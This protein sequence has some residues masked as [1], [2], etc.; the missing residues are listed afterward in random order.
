MEKICVKDMVKNVSC[1]NCL[2]TIMKH[3]KIVDI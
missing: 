2:N 1:P 3:G